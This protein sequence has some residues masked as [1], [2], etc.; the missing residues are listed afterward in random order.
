MVDTICCT[1]VSFSETIDKGQ[2]GEQSET[3][4]SSSSSSTTPTP[5]PTL[6]ITLKTPVSVTENTPTLLYNLQS[7]QTYPTLSPEAAVTFINVGLIVSNND[8]INLGI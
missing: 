6:L 3:E 5:T 2:N 4:S 7:F 8:C 1:D